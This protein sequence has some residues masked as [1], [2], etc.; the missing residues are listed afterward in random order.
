V[1]ANLREQ[2]DEELLPGI[3]AA[4]SLP[5][6]QIRAEL[7]EQG[8][9]VVQ[10]DAPLPSEAELA[11]TCQRLVER[12]LRQATLRGAIA[13]SAGLVA[14]PP[15]ALA[16]LVQMVRLAQRLA[17][18]HGHDPETDRGR[19][20]LLRAVA[21]GLEVELPAQTTMG[22]RLG[23]VASSA[24]VRRSET[25]ADLASTLAL[26]AAVSLA[27][28]VG[29]AIPV[30]GAGLGALQARRTMRAA[31]E[32]MERTLS[33]AQ[34]APLYPEGSLIEAEELPQR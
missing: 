2:L 25:T 30:L 12:S 24:L 28:R 15:E 18:V 7:L 20:L 29:R 17:V 32:R 8:L 27:G 10:V 34:E 14:I 9:A 6:A 13:G 21:A 23:Q 4:V 31:A 11:A 5:T 16:A 33:R 1:L 3:Y 19:L 26:R 22:L